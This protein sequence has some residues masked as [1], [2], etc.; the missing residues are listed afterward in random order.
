M[1]FNPRY[2]I[3]LSLGLVLFACG[4][5]DGG[6]TTTPTT[7][8]AD[9]PVLTLENESSLEGNDGTSVMTFT[10]NL[11]GTYT[12]TVSA[13]YF[14]ID[15][16]AL[17]GVDYQPVAETISFTSPETS[18]EIS[19]M[20]VADNL[21]EGNERFTLQID[22]LNNVTTANGNN[23]T[24]V[25]IIQND[26]SNTIIP[27]E[28]YSTPDNYDSWKIKWADEFNEEGINKEVWDFELGNGCNNGICGWGNNEL[29]Q[30]SD[31]EKNARIENGKLVIE[32]H[33]EGSAASY[34]SARMITKNTKT[35]Q[36]GRI[37]IRAK[38]PKGQGLWPAIWMLGANIDDVGWP[39]CG[40]IDIMELVGHKPKV[41]HG[42][43][44]YGP[45]SPNNRSM[46]GSTTSSNGDFSESFHVFT[47]AWRAGAMYWYVNDE[48]YYE[49]NTEQ[50]NGV[51]YPFNKPFFFILNVAVGGN[52]PGNPDDTTVFPQRMEV[53]YIRVFERE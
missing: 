53:D 38:L 15:G 31:Q 25:G 46:G 30:Y 20:L 19:I 10:V 1:L 51:A 17:A 22:Q 37:D 39:A 36:F 24:A 49:V 40:E 32:A 28:G 43:V 18:K 48:L 34:S 44:H 35:F 8:A 33:Q 16:S 47:L 42:T 21:K 27:E 9:L 3:F 6:G 13:N 11:E 4:K 14:T 2:F 12:G 7:P 5:D 29:E 41:A 52:W 45:P 50:F 26:D 23:V